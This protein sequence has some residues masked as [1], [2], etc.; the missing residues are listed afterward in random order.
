MKCFFFENSKKRILILHKFSST[1]V[2]AIKGS[3]C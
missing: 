1:L 3:V 2:K